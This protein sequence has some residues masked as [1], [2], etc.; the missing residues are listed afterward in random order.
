MDF[1][2]CVLKPMKIII[3][4]FR[5]FVFLENEINIY[6]LNVIYGDIMAGKIFTNNYNVDL[7]KITFSLFKSI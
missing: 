4:D 7:G 3:L 5:R 2:G 6:Y 1:K